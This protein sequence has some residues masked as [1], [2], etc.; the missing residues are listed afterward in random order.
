MPDRFYL[1]MRKRVRA[2]LPLVTAAL[3]DAYL[4]SVIKRVC[5]TSPARIL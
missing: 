3:I 4:S 2:L 5:V 1:L